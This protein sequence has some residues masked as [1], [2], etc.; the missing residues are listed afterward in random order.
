MKQIPLSAGYIALVDDE[1]FERAAQF[2]WSALP[3]RSPQTKEVTTVYAQRHVTL[4]DGRRG[5]ERL[6]RFIL[7]ISDP[8]VVVDHRDGDGLNNQRS[9]LRVCNNTQNMM[10]LVRIRPHSSRFKGVYWNKALQKWHSRISIHGHRV[11]LGFFDS[12]EDAAL[13]YNDAAVAN[14]GEFARLNVL[15]NGRVA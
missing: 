6:H 3:Q 10:N 8:K 12:E 4:S 11:H 7:E 9:N 2:N 14:F 5:G 15:E 1:D 13:R